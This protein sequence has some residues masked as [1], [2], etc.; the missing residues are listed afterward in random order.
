MKNRKILNIIFPL[1]ALILA[2]CS[3]DGAGNQDGV[4]ELTLWHMEE[5]LNR[6]EGFK[7]VIENFNEQ[8]DNVEITPEVQ[9]WDDA[10]SEF[11]A[12]IQAG[13]GPELLFTLPDY[14]ALIQDL[15][16]V[17][18]VD[19][20]VENLDD[21]YGFIDSSVE[22][23]QYDDHI[24][25]VPIFGMV[26][27]LWYREDI[28]EDNNLDAP[29]NWQ[30]LTKTAEEITDNGVNGIALPAS[31]SQATDQVLYSFMIAAGAKDIIDSENNVTFDTPETVEAYKKYVELLEFSPGDSNIFE[32]GE[33]QALFN[34]GKAAMAIEKGQYLSTFEDESGQPSDDL[35]LTSMPISEDGEEGSIYYSNGIMVLTEEEKEQEAIKEFFEFLYEPKNYTDFINAEPGLFLPVTEEAA[36]S[37]DYWDNPMVDKYENQIETLIEASENGELFGFTN[38]V[39]S[40]IG[41]ITGPNYLAQTLQKITEDDMSAEEA[42]KWGQEQMEEAVK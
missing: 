6:V 26:Q 8:S 37:G 13:N 17:Q 21:K 40:E 20:I 3:N 10:Y 1:V 29:G 22:P 23:Y 36:K 30:E 18:P 42:V 16:V 5:P 2:S 15:G 32:W 38:G 39:S 12:A 11:P 27:G 14:T 33:P 24:W 25:S 4:T 19:D 41:Q 28:F 31:K 34:E 35:G 7:D 9:S